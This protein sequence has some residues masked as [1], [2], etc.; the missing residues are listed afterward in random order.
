MIKNKYKKS[1]ADQKPIYSSDENEDD[2]FDGFDLDTR[3]RK[4][5]KSIPTKALKY[6]NNDSNN[7]SAGKHSG[8]ENEGLGSGK[9]SNDV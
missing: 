5:D 6:F 1:V 7:A 8:S 9:D 2:A 3:R 4:K